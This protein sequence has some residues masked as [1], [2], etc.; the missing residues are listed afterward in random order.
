MVINKPSGTL[1][2]AGT[3]RTANTW[4]YT[5]GTLDPGSS[6]LVFAGG[7]ITGLAQPQRGRHPSDHVDRRRHHADRDGLAQPDQRCAQRDRH[8]WPPRD[9]SARPPPRPAGRP[10]CSSTAAARRPSTGAATTAAGALPPVVINKPS[11]T[12]TLAGTIRTATGWT[13]TAGTVDP[14]SST[15]VFAGGTITGSHSL[16][17]VDFR[18][19]TTIA[20]GTTL[21]VLGTTTLTA[22]NLNT[23][24]LAAAG[25]INQALGY[26]GGSATLLV[27]G[28]GAQTL[29]GASTT[30]SGNLPM[31][32]HQ[33]AS[34]TLTLAGT[35]RTANTWTYTAGTLDPGSSTLVF[36]GGTI[37]GSH[38]LNAVDVRATTSIAA[39]TTLTVTGSLSLTS[40]ALN[41]TGTWPPRDRSARPPPRP[42][43]RPPCSSTAAGAQTLTG[44]ATTAA[45]ALPPVVINKPSGTLT[46]AGTI[47][48]A[49][50]WTYTAGTVDPGSST[51]VFA[52]GTVRSVGM[53]F[54]DVVGNGGTTTLGTA[55][56]VL[57]DLSVNAGTFTTSASNFALAIS[58][59]LTVVGTFR[60]NGSSVSVAGNIVNNGTIVQGTSTLTLNGS[61]GQTIGG[62]SSPS[63]VQPRRRRPGGRNARHGR[64]HDRHAHADERELQPRKPSSDDQQPHRRHAAPTS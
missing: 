24:T 16:N 10:P 2:L 63:G 39:G 11:G 53:A 21:T 32:R 59:S 36:A 14:G 8:A 19:T 1:T 29:T 35:L 34:G 44:A 26:G 50:G 49:T 17:A 27:N 57:H 51:L 15:L 64:G 33:Q 41:G 18:A 20:A 56:T 30:A 62:S 38:S 7:T 40:G 55:M 48:T 6:T 52:G 9:R 12:L 58:G 47:R 42:A 43:G 28:S 13:Y 3:I 45:G 31:R 4:T 23:G 37:T 46:L 60:E 61:L 25:D 22:G 5:A 54:Y